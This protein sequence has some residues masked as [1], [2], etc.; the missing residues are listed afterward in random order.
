MIESAEQIRPY[1]DQV[2]IKEDAEEE[3]TGGGLYVPE[4]AQERPT[5]GTVLAVGPGARNERTGEREP[6]NLDPGDRVIYGKYTGQAVETREDGKLILTRE[7]HVFGLYL[8][9]GDGPGVA[10]GAGNRRGPVG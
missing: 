10:A 7:R 6:V 4:Q 9:D 2:L 5:R 1:G 3:M 8:G